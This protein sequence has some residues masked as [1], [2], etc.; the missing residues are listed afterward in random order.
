MPSLNDVTR[1]TGTALF[2]F[3]QCD[4]SNYAAV[5]SMQIHGTRAAQKLVE[6]LGPDS[7][8]TK[9]E[10]TAV[11][12]SLMQGVVQLIQVSNVF[13]VDRLPWC[14]FVHVL[15]CHESKI[16]INQCI[17]A[18]SPRARNR[19]R[20]FYHTVISCFVSALVLAYMFSN[21]CMH[22][23]MQVSRCIL[24]PW[25]DVA[26]RLF[27][28]T[29]HLI[30]SSLACCVTLLLHRAKCLCWLYKDV[31]HTVCPIWRSSYVP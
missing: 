27:T 23:Y 2:L 24:F 6:C 28:T 3:F 8:P 29:W 25:P 7:K 30:S 12:Q 10:I 9:P 21:T 4:K 22:A 18:S 19:T 5:M 11:V 1:C 14:V 13:F 15:A 31:I 20:R 17:G 26:S 16:S